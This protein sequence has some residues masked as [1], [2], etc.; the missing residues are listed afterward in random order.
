MSDIT[1]RKR[2]EA[3]RQQ[4][5]DELERLVQ[6]R[7][8]ALTASNNQLQ[9]EI[10][11]R[12]A[13]QQKLLRE[14]DLLRRLFHLQEEERQLASY[15]VHDGVV[16]YLVGAK[17]LL[18]ACNRPE[19]NLPAPI[20]TLISRASDQ[21]HTAIERGR[22]LIDHLRPMVI[23]ELGLVAGIQ[24]LIA[25]TNAQGIQTCLEIEGEF[26]AV[27]DFLA[28]TAFRI[29]QAALRNVCQHSQAEQ[30]V[31]RLCCTTQLLTVEIMDGGQG[32]DPHDIPVPC[33]GIRSIQERTRLLG[34]QT[35]LNSSPSEGTRLLVEL[36]LAPA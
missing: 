10:A 8:A 36:P 12:M 1:E 35:L 19:L 32:F 17:M 11:E 9:A 22:R 25:E 14:Q 6:D 15:Q 16:Q 3:V 5:S 23:D 4:A 21:L 29:V 18:D 31:V 26:E 2:L 7:T 30:A 13:A 34:G 20:I 33:F 24:F 28:E 27:P